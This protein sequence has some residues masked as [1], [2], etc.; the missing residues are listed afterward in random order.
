MLRQA[1]NDTVALAVAMTA[2]ENGVLDI[3]V[4]VSNKTGHR[5]PSGVGFRRAFLELLLMRDNNGTPEI[6]WGSGRTNAV[7]VI[8]DGA[9]KPLATEFLDQ[10]APGRTIPLYQPHYQTITGEDQ[11]QIYEELTLNARNEFTTSFI[12]RNRHPKDNRLLPAGYLEP[13]S[14]AFEQK[15]GASGIIKAFMEATRPEG[16]QGDVETCPEA[17]IS[18]AHCQQ[19][20]DFQPGQDTVHYRIKLPAGSDPRQLTIKA[21]MYYQAIPPYWLHQR[22]T[23]APEQPATRRL[24]YLSSHLNTTGTP[25]ENWKLPLVSTVTS[26]AAFLQK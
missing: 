8:V 12:H 14:A 26:V 6:V 16:L 11:V 18:S 9:G 22:F 7:G 1:R 20:A 3:S 2:L 13:G 25:I 4:S 5:F 10:T 23:L 21:T 24:Y 17:D 15:F 19:D